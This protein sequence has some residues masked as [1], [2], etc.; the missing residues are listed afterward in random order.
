MFKQGVGYGKKRDNN[1]K[2]LINL[3]AQKPSIIFTFFRLLLI[4]H[5]GEKK[6]RNFAVS[7]E[8]IESYE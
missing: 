3:L 1:L 5:A 4:C 6:I 8:L 7:I 2:K